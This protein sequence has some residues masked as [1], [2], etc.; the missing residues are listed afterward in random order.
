MYIIGEMIDGS[1]WTDDLKVYSTRD[2]ALIDLIPKQ[3]DLFT[4]NFRV[5]DLRE[6]MS[7]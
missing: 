5:I 2:K 7:E 4:E 3:G 6:R 1:F